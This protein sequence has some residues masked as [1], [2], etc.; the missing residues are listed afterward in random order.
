MNTGF[1]FKVE[2][3]WAAIQG[4]KRST[5]NNSIVSAAIKMAKHS[6]AS[7]IQFAYVCLMCSHTVNFPLSLICQVP[8]ELFTADLVMA[9]RCSNN[10]VNN[11]PLKYTSTHIHL[12]RFTQKHMVGPTHWHMCAYSVWRNTHARK[13]SKKLFIFS[14]QFATFVLALGLSVC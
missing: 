14:P 5:V 1:D 2:K 6:H 10:Y 11:F 7:C 4:E 8:G 13:N 3:L 9:Q 12:H